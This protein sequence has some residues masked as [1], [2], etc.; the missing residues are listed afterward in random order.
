MSVFLPTVREKEKKPA[1]IQDSK[2]V[3]I[4][5]AFSMMP[6]IPRFFA[7]K[8]YSLRC[9]YTLIISSRFQSLT[10]LIPYP[11]SIAAPY[12]VCVRRK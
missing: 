12:S 2:K 7:R 1:L 9:E 6:F 8:D 3:G 11:T 4:F 10:V 5:P